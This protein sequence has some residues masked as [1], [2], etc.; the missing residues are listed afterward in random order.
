MPLILEGIRVLEVAEYGMVPSAGAVLGEWGADVIKIEHAHRGDPIRGL[1]TA[2]VAP[3]TNGF[4]P[5]HEPVNRNKRSV[6]VDIGVPEGREIILDLAR[7]ADVFLTSFLP[8]ARRKLGLE[9]EDLRAVNPKIIYGRGSAHGQLGDEAEAGGFDGLT[10]WLRCGIAM[11]TI[12]TG[13]TDLTMQPGPGFGD[14]QTGMTLAGGIAGALFHR[15]RTGEAL[16]VDTSLLAQGCWAMMGSVVAVNL[17]GLDEMPRDHRDRK[18]APNPLMNTYRTSDNRWFILGML[19]PDRYWAD[20]CTAIGHDELIADPRFADITVRTQHK[21]LCIETLDKIFGS[22]PLAHWEER[23][24]TQG[25]P[26]SSAQ[27]VGD[28][29]RDKQ[30]WANGYFQTVDYGD[31]R[32]ITLGSAP[33]QFNK[34]AGVLSRAPEHGESTEEVLLELGHSWEDISRFREVGAI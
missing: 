9:V 4:T 31:G 19:Q 24:A 8:S 7:Q 15:E 20:L 27:R 30:A 23:L 13:C 21:D 28:L 26:W 34:E 33:V 32:S 5:M 16:E 17:A 14:V 6:G 10:Y 1:S 11:G 29:G 12:P 22:A 18:N 2:G 25:G 3:G